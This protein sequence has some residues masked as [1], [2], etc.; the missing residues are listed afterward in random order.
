MRR[1][2]QMSS[3]ELP[4]ERNSNKVLKS[5]KMTLTPGSTTYNNE[6]VYSNC[7]HMGCKPIERRGSHV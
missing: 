1:T 7:K 4:S 5:A 2:A 3:S 6:R